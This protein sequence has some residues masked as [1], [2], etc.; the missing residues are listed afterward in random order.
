MQ[1]YRGYFITWTLLPRDERKPDQLTTPIDLI[2]TPKE[3]KPMATQPHPSPMPPADMVRPHQM[4]PPQV[5]K[6][7]IPQQQAMVL[8]TLVTMPLHLR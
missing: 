2:V 4:Q 5:W 3:S 1:D 7:L 6:T 8:Q